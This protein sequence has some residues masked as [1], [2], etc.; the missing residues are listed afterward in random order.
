LGREGAACELFPLAD[1]DAKSTWAANQYH[2][3]AA[4]RGVVQIIRRS[5]GR[6]MQVA[7]K[8]RGLD[9]QAR[10]ELTAFAG[11]IASLPVWGPTNMPQIPRV[12]PLAPAELGLPHD[13]TQTV[14]TGR[15]LMARGPTLKLPSPSQ[16]IWIAY[17]RQP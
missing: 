5:E 3:A 11:A 1:A 16:V 8:L 9:A 2:L 15:E 4:E 7:C 12:A 14:M 17:Q 10:Y 6:P 13:G